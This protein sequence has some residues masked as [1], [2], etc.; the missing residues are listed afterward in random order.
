MQ[1]RQAP[2]SAPND[3][4]IRAS[5]NRST[6]K[7]GTAVLDRLIRVNSFSK[8]ITWPNRFGGCAAMTFGGD[9]V[10][11]SPPCDIKR[12]S[13]RLLF[14]ASKVLSGASILG[15][16]HRLIMRMAQIRAGSDCSPLNSPCDDLFYVTWDSYWR[17][18]ESAL[19]KTSEW[20]QADVLSTWPLLTSPQKPRSLG[21]KSRNRSC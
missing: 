20:Q 14:T 5:T 9:G 1:L 12:D 4:F 18:Q 13:A 8:A 19:A 2:P 15:R 17:L 6:G 11:S 10:A 7:D 16:P 3:D 21:L